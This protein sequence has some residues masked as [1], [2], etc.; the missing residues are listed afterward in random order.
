[1]ARVRFIKHAQHCGF[2]LGEINELLT[3]K[4]R[5]SACC[6]DV[7]KLAVEKKLQLEAKIKAMGAMSKALD[8]LISDCPEDGSPIGDC[9]I[10]GAMER[11]GRGANA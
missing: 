10:L 1:V 6:D 9:P 4:A 7:R 5:D 3:L 8:L 2:T 11:V